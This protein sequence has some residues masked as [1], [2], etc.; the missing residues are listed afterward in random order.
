MII[1][2]MGNLIVM[3]MVVV[4]CVKDAVFLELLAARNDKPLL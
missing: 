3:M 4:M 2:M 1:T